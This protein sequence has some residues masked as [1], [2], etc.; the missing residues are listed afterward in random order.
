[1]V[2]YGSRGNVAFRIIK[3]AA[4]MMIAACFLI[5]LWWPA[6]HVSVWA[7]LPASNPF[8]APVAPP[9]A[10]AQLA[11]PVPN[12]GVPSLVAVPTPPAAS[13][14]STAQAF[15]CSCF[16]PG[17]GTAW[18]GTVVSASFFDAQQAAA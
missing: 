6:G 13:P 11:A 10:P 3:I 18:M 12:E 5:I 4:V 9:S 14:T 7:Q 8:L 2:T 1:M 17:T 16:G 15:N